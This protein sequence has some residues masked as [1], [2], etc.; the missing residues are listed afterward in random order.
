MMRNALQKIACRREESIIIGDRMD[1]DIIAGIESVIDTCLV[2]SG[3]S[4]ENTASEFPYTPHTILN[5]VK[6]IIDND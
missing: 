4:D 2:L 1:T 5:G 6:D 3:I